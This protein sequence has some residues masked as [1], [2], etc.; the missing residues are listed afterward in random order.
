MMSALA[1]KPERVKS[2]VTTLLGTDIIL[3]LLVIFVFYTGLG[4]FVL[5]C[6]DFLFPASWKNPEFSNVIN[7][8]TYIIGF[9]YYR[10]LQQLSD[11]YMSGPK[12]YAQLTS[13]IVT[14]SDLFFSLHSAI[15]TKR[16][17]EDVLV[18]VKEC[19]IAMVD[20]GI[21]LFAKYEG[22]DSRRSMRRLDKFAR[23]EQDSIVREVLQNQEKAGMTVDGMR[24]LMSI[25]VEKIKCREE[26][27]HFS[28]GDT[29][30]CTRQLDAIS[31]MIEEMDVSFKI[32]EPAVFQTLLITTLYTYF[33]IW[34]PYSLWTVLE[35]WA[36]VIVYTIIMFILTNI[37]LIRTWLGDPFSASR[38]LKTV[39]YEAWKESAIDRIISKYNKAQ[40]VNKEPAPERPNVI[41]RQQ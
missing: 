7:P 31:D 32:I 1:I 3:Y 24:D 14:F 2:F 16:A 38:P 34:V 12:Q 10:W 26:G 18:E 37:Y 23:G 25:I 30:M 6:Y 20:Y 22:R 40:K 19:L 4:M 21:Y 5:A 36:S 35:Y 27:G 39:D 15:Q 41:F 11:G 28:V 8:L 29:T 17:S 13:K 33:I 9:L